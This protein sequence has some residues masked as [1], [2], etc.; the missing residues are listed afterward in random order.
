MNSKSIYYVIERQESADTTVEAYLVWK[1]SGKGVE[2]ELAGS[3]PTLAC[4]Q[5]SVNAR[6]HDASGTLAAW[7]LVPAADDEALCAQASSL[8]RVAAD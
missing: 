5:A 2:A 6:W 8:P 4:A 1:R 3:Y 7:A